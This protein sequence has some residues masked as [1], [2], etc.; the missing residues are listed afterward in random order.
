MNDILWKSDFKSRRQDQLIGCKTINI[1]E[2]F[3]GVHSF[4]GKTVNS[5]PINLKD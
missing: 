1:P 3:S 2:I 4:M 5:L